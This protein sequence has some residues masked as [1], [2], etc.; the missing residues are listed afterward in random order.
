MMRILILN[1]DYP[2]F[3]ASLYRDNPGLERESYARQMQIRNASIFGVN[4]YYSY[5][6]AKQGHEAAEVHVNNRWLQYAWARENNL[7]IAPPQTRAEAP[8]TLNSA[9]LHG[10]KKL[11]HPFLSPLIQRARNYVMPGWE[12]RILDAQ[13]DKFRPDV[14]L[15]QELAYV[16]NQTLRRYQKNGIFIIGQIASALP[17]NAE[18]DSYNLVISSLP[19]LVN[20]F[21]NHSIPAELNRLAFEP[22][23]LDI[24]GTQP[25]RD[26]DLSF[27][28]S[29]SPEHTERIKLLERLARQTS[30][31]IWGTGIERLPK[32]SPLHAIHQG[33]AW[34]REMY[35][36]LRRSRVT[37]NHHINL[38]AD[39]ANNMRLYEATGV[40]AM[41][42]TDHKRNLA[43]IFTPGE[44]VAVYADEKDCVDQI[45]FFLSNEQARSTIAAAGQKKTLSTHHYNARTQEIGKLVE[46]YRK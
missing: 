45:D 31:K 7:A 5:N 38:A 36:V 46:K 2:R 14:I 44:E 20:W 37:L 21:R 22:R 34:G 39:W 42:L 30:L 27:V 17:K 10:A 26:I 28:G 41:L 40:G 35:N 23:I 16:D 6:F 24:L 25:V 32:S 1:A 43:E 8:S 11:A 15:N 19:N 12:A 18:Y 9:L 13:V 33:E 29:L 4:D 3:L